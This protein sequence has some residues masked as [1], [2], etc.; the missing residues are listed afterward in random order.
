MEAGLMLSEM[1][2]SNLPVI[3]KKG[4]LDFFILDCEHGG[5]DYSEVSALVMTARL[6]GLKCIIRLADNTRKD[7]VKFMDMGAD[8]LLLQMT[9]TASDIEKVVEYAKYSPIGKRGISTMRAHTLYDPPK[10]LDY[11]E[12]ANARTEIYAQI[13]T[14]AGVKNVSEILAVE[15]V[16]GFLM[17]PNDLSCDFGCLSDDH[18]PQ[19]LSAIEKTTNEAKRLGKK[20][21]IITGNEAYLAK[22]RS[23]GMTMFCVGS[24]LNLLK[25]GIVNTV[26]QI[27]AF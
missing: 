9:D 12:E 22:G 24:E 3:L 18:A 14:S 20:S 4:G 13:E 11:M 27:K 17:G 26:N 19:I 8:G 7:I 23:C 10:L 5:F 21:G 6:A 16:S 15:G 1:A 25:T 2:F